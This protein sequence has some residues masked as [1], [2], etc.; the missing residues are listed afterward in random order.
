MKRRKKGVVY[1][2]ALPVPYCRAQCH[3]N[4]NTKKGVPF[5]AC[6]AL[7]AGTGPGNQKVIIFILATGLVI[8]NK[9]F[10]FTVQNHMCLF[11]RTSTSSKHWFLILIIAIPS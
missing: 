10:V 2:L 9:S 1:Q 8:R 11:A 5:G 6:F 4:K 7:G 3:F